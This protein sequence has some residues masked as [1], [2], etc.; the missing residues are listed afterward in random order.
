MCFQTIQI[1]R[2]TLDRGLESVT[3]TFSLFETLLE[4]RWV[5]K[6]FLTGL[7]TVNIRKASNYTLY[8]NHLI[9][10]INLDLKMSHVRGS[11]TI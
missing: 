11:H 3:Q 2:Y 9:F 10:Q 4:M 7:Y 5:V 1:I 8:L 6:L